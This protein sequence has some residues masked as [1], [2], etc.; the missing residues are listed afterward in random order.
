[1]FSMRM[2]CIKAKKEKNV[3]FIPLFVLVAVSVLVGGCVQINVPPAATPTALPTAE[4]TPEPSPVPTPTPTPSPTQAGT[5]AM[6]MKISP[7]NDSTI[8]GIVTIEVTAS[9]NGTGVVAFAIQG[10]GVP[11]LDQTG[12]NL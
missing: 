12:P 2:Q 11:S 3:F 5:Q 7:S 6:I 4:P 8:Q 10:K 1:M 9:P